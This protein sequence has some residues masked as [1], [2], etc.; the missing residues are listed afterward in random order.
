MTSGMGPWMGDQPAVRLLQA[1]GNTENQYG[2]ISP[3]HRHH[4]IK[5]YKFYGYKAIRTLIG[6]IDQSVR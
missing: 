4:E 5:A 2:K 1:Q 6:S 3:L